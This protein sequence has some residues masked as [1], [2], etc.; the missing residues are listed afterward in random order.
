[1]T[2]NDGYV[3][4]VD[5]PGAFFGIQDPGRLSSICAMNGFE[6]VDIDEPFTY[7]ELGC[8]NGMTS[9]V[10][11]AANPQGSFHAADFM[12]THIAAGRQLAAEAGLDNLRLLDNSFAELAAGK[13]EV[14]PLDFITMHGV[15]SWVAAENRRHI[16]DFVARNLK[17]GGIVFVSYDAMPGWSSALPLQRLVLEHAVSNPQRSDVRLE[18]AREFLDRLIDAKA[19]YFGAH[20]NPVLASR[21]KTLKTA[22]PAHLV[23]QYLNRGWQPLYHADVARDFQDAK[24]EFAGGA[25]LSHRFL[26]RNLSQ[27]CEA[28]LAGIA[29]PQLRETV[30]DYMLNTAFR[31]DLFVRGARRMSARRRARWLQ[32]I[33]LALCVPRAGITLGPPGTPPIGAGHTFAPALDALAQGPRS[34][35]E[36]APLVGG[37]IEKIIDLASVLSTYGDG[38]PYLLPGGPTQSSTG[39]DRMNRVVARH[40]MLDD[41]Y[42]ALASPVLRSGV[43]T[44][45]VERLVYHQ[46]REQPERRDTAAIAQSVCEALRAQRAG[47]PAD[48]DLRKTVATILEWKV[49]VWQQLRIFDWEVPM[50]QQ[51]GILS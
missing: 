49:P 5:C 46:L 10:L 35:G 2:W 38:T 11:A 47:E 12:P 34:L 22:L 28:L 31:S 19:D 15:Y 51:L 42:Q 44:S 24:L 23:H 27:P 25:C 29:D 8:G 48:M 33:G 37:D 26:R 41:Q 3:V 50:W 6:P 4:D 45:Q 40:S 43:C 21:L 7:F 32:R 14:P 36:L 1:M 18:R 16:V 39:A 9:A 20:A 17:P 30:S 13:V